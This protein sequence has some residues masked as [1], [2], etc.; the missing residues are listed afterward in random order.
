ML[1]HANEEDDDGAFPARSVK[2]KV[3]KDK[4]AGA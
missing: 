2:I 4:G 3:D 1:T